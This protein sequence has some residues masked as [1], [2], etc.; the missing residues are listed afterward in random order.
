M[1]KIL[2]ATLGN[3]DLQFSVTSNLPVHCYDL[4]EK[5][6]SD[7]GSN[8]VIKKSGGGFLK[9]SEAILAAYDQLDELVCFPMIQTYLEKMTEKPDMVVLV[10]TQQ[11]PLDSQDCCYVAQ[12]LQKWLKNKDY[13]V[14]FY[15]LE[16][17][18]VN[19]PALVEVFTLLYD[20]Y[21]DAHIFVGNS[22]GT[23][24]MR[25]ASYAAGFFRGI[26]YI[27]L[28]ARDKQ[29]NITN[30]RAQERLVLRHVAE[31]MLSNFD[32]SGLL[33]LP[34]KDDSL[35]LLAEYALARLSIDFERANTMAQ[36]IGD[37]TLLL[38]DSMNIREKEREVWVSA[39]IKYHQ[40]SWGDYLWR[41]FLIQDNLWIPLIEER[42]SG[43]IIHNKNSRF[44][45]WNDLL[46]SN[47]DLLKYLETYRI[48]TRPLRYEEPTKIVYDVIRRFYRLGTP[49]LNELDEIMNQGMRDLRNGV[50]HNYKGINRE[51]IEAELLEKS[52]IGIEAFHE[53]MTLHTGIPKNSFGIYD[54]LNN[55]IL[56]YFE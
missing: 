45:E 4:F 26:Q 7:T 33:Q 47:P 16:C 55:Q 13:V 34:F 32:Y 35:K 46:H 27:T 41:L 42:L 36:H 38:P 53:K 14:D 3:R 39:K 31:N 30:F 54:R 24:D 15:P 22:G 49:I 23:P 52:R 44:R 51:I 29:V 17:A 43:S 21:R 56:G 6:G 9:N 11:E 20:G 10:S 5:G 48:G 1:K 50:A 19:F 28:Q 25:A 18:P 37:E 12:F 40:K 8:L 2:I